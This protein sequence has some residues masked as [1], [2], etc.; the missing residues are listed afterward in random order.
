MTSASAR[1][2]LQ[3]GAVRFLRFRLI[4]MIHTEDDSLTTYLFQCDEEG[5]YAVSLDPAGANI[6][7]RFCP[8]TWK[9]MTTFKLG[10]QEPVPAAI[11]PEPIIRGIRADGYYIWREG[12]TY[13]TTQ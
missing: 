10:V 13:G 7:V 11:A 3:P 4:P 5:L 1:E 2:R 9:L 12:Y 8:Q 6:P